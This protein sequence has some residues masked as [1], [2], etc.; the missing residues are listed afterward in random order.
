MSV[1]L[2]GLVL[3]LSLFF[4]NLKTFS[5]LS[6][7]PSIG[8]F[9]VITIFHNRTI[10]AVSIIR[11]W[12]EIKKSYLARAILDWQNIPAEKIFSQSDISPIEIDLDLTGPR[13]LHQL[14]DFSKSTEGS[15][16]LKKLLIENPH[17]RNEV[18]HRQNL[19]NEL[20][21][22]SHFRN[23]FIL[24]NS[25][26]AK[27]DINTEALLN[28][29]AESEKT[30]QIKKMLII[31]G[32]ICAANLVFIILAIL[33]IMPT[34]YLYTTFFY[35]V[36][37]NLNSKLIKASS[38]EAEIINDQFRKVIGIL[39]FIENYKF[40][41]RKNLSDLC[42]PLSGKT[43]SP[44]KQLNKI[45]SVLSLLSMRSNP[46]VWFLFMLICP[47]DYYLAYCVEVYKKGIVK[48]LP[49][50]LDVWHKLEAFVSIANFAYINPD[51]SFPRIGK[52]NKLEFTTKGMGH[53]L[54][55]HEKNVT[56][57]FQIH[58]VGDISIITGSNMSGKS[59]FL[60]TVGINISL[61]YS[62]APV[63][64]ESF[65]LSM[66]RIFTCIRVS[67]SVIDGISYFY[68]EV[69]RLRDLLDKIEIP[70]E[71]PILFLIDEIF[72]GTN[73]IERLQG[74]RAI[75]KVLADKN[76]SG[77][78]STHDLELVKLAEEIPSISNYHFREEV[79]DKI[80][81]FDYKLKNGPCPTTN[82][83]KIMQANGLPI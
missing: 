54:I 61:A 60:R 24:T 74:S 81:L 68:A 71:I 82:A 36:S 25:L 53:P 27:D 19:V 16:L 43:K 38:S 20:L 23:K 22:L 83:L 58:D 37:Y 18:I 40:G 30:N 32:L 65:S 79:L 52:D 31:L 1:F 50:W 51:Y 21:S 66:V 80:M 44:T 45:N 5:L 7:I 3:Y 6:L 41:A 42:S 55:N 78:I 49:I 73:N 15:Q 28:W 9:I 70:N 69:K 57:N 75:I 63:Y 4:L 67:D 34:F 62:G 2:T 10:Y 33:G 14:L 26:S 39:S 46:V 17:G 59:T 77:L 76:G 56:N 29:L 35:F 12:I 11:K 8:L 64:A 13:S 48:N 72:K 47:I